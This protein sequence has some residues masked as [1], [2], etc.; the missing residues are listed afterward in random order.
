MTLRTLDP[1][2]VP[3]AIQDLL[4]RL[5]RAGHDA[6]LVGGCVRDLLRGVPVSDW[7]IATNARPEEV[8]RLFPSAI[9]TGLK[10]GTVTVPTEAGPCEVTT[11]RIE[12]GYSDAR[13]PDHVEFVPDLEADLARRD[14]TVNAIAWD[15]LGGREVDPFGGR[16]DLEAR[17]LRAVGSPVERFREDGLRP[18]RAARFSAT[19]EFGLSPETEAALGE[20]REQVARV[21][22]ERLRDELTKLLT[23]NRPSEGFEVLRRSGLLPLLLPEL[24]ACVAV[25][26][27]RYH[28]Y[29]VYYHTIYTVDA[30][31]AEKP[32]VRLAALFHDVGK[33]RTRVER[34]NG[35]ATFYN[36]EFESA[37]LAEEAMTRLRF[38]RDTIE[39][40][41]HLVRHHM[42]DYRPEWTD[43]AVRRFVQ[44]VGV[45]KIADLF[46][47][48]IA[49]N[50]GNGLKTGFPH[51]LEE[52]R[53]R[54]EGVLAA[55]A[56][57]TLSDLK[58]DGEDVMR[59]LGLP[60][61]PRV[62]EVLG[63]LLEQV[64]EEPALNERKR[65][66]RRAREAF[67]IDT[68]GSGA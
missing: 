31:P 4:R 1:K 13:R 24:Q 9:P 35:D 29:D 11:F 51:Y 55:R 23:A 19:L 17:V 25:P 15:P 41:V 61:G 5:Q 62:G 21:A 64:V 26:Q 2:R 67:S 52:F 7:D 48:R 45:E 57:L 65:L 44:K 8:L 59:E 14:F 56:A 40:V 58:V 42:F 33:P 63:W 20:A 38:G 30:A 39:Q 6:Y 3:P 36:H 46:D 27:N 28:A 60:P 66:L 34:E 22:A 37:R 49:D 12:W 18:I 32:V 16:A 53:V 47:L 50:V 43:A 10:H 68:R 54:I